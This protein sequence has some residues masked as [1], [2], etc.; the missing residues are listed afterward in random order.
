MKR[1]FAL[2]GDLIKIDLN[3]NA[4][5]E[6]LNYNEKP[7]IST[8]QVFKQTNKYILKENKSDLDL[9]FRYNKIFNWKKKS[10]LNKIKVGNVEMGEEN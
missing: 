3:E 5:Q 9:Y 4:N 8:L 6:E 2:E 7:H 10:R 1:E